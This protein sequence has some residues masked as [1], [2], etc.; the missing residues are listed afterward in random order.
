MKV[1]WLAF[2]GG[3][4]SFTATS[5]GALLTFAPKGQGKTNR[6]NFSIDFALGLMV[7]ASAFTLIGPAALSTAQSA[8]SYLWIALAAIS[9]V[10]FVYFLKAQISHLESTHQFKT[11][12]VILAS[13]LML[14]NF[15]EGLA[16]GSALAGLHF[17]AALPILGGIALQN[18]PEG[19]LMVLCLEAMGWKR[20]WAILGGVASGLVELFGGGLAGL[21][22]Q[23]VQ[24]ILSLLL[25]FA[26][27]SMLASVFI[28]MKESLIP[29]RTRIWS[30]QFLAGLACIPILQFLTF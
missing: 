26:G 23:L 3:F 6:W 14:H 7:S 13:V 4:V 5:L 25:S 12:H 30:F 11:S 16:S 2:L 9:G 10:G 21:L 27:G 22:L 8:T 20:R 28:E 15:P 19:A 29:I 1:F 17:Q 18:V 24:G